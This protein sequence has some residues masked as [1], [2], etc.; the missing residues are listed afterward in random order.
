MEV[1]RKE[2]L[3]YLGYGQNQPGQ[4]ILDMLEWAIEEILSCAKPGSAHKLFNCQINAPKITIGPMDITSQAL[5]KHLA[6]CQQAVLFAATLGPL[7]DRLLKRYA[8]IDMSRGVILQAAGAAIIECYC[9]HCQKQIAQGLK[10][11]GL[12]LKPRFSPGY[13]DFSLNLQPQ[14]LQI[15]DCSRKIGLTATQSMMLAPSKSVTAVMGIT[16]TQENC[17][18]WGCIHCGKT[19][20]A[21]KRSE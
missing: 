6:G 15:L 18:K 12:H 10:E 8:A 4:E 17:P 11:K 3:R 5:C 20:C 9:D 14:L 19:D 2:A 16:C 7:P 1:N 13:G 21:Y